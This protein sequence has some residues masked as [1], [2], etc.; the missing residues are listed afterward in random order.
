MRLNHAWIA[1]HIPHQGD[2][3]LLDEVLEWN[4]NEISCRTGS[5]RRR[6]NPLRTAHELPAVCGIEYA[7]QAI[8]LHGVL[9]AA[10]QASTAP[11]PGMLASVR[12]VTLH[13]DRLDDIEA[14]L[15]I[16]GTRVSATADAL[17]YDFRVA[18]DLRVLLSGRST[19]YLRLPLASTAPRLP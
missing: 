19:I 5:H 14:D 2:M 13:V 12:N 10:R 4:V 11:L 16:V 17:L 3:C 15:M 9:C 6:D 18:W 8:A 7:A 1:A